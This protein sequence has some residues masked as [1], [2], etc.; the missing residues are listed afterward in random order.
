MLIILVLCVLLCLVVG[1]LGYLIIFSGADTIRDGSQPTKTPNIKPSPSTPNLVIARGNPTLW[2]SKKEP[3]FLRI[4]VFF[5]CL[6]LVIGALSQLQRWYE[7]S[8]RLVLTVVLVVIAYGLFRL[9]SWARSVTVAILW[10]FIF[11]IVNPFHARD[12]GQGTL[13][14]TTIW[15]IFLPAIIGILWCLHILGK[16]KSRFR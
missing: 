4:V 3:L 16:H 7:S 6:L 15:A 12:L 13:S 8:F 5:L 14:V 9:S 1:V 10:L 11:G 2:L